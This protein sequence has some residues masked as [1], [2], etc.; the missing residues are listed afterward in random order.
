M[1]GLGRLLTLMPVHG[2]VG[3]EAAWFGS[4]GPVWSCV[5][6]LVWARQAEDRRVGAV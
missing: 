3:L 5:D 6:R 2:A 4:R 1:T